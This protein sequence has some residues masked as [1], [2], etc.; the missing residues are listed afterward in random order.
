M[1]S[2]LVVPYRHESYLADLVQYLRV[3]FVGVQ[4]LTNLTTPLSNA[5]VFAKAFVVEYKRDEIGSH[6]SSRPLVFDTHDS[7]RTLDP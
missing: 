2:L 4:S 1:T 7:R 3:C 5:H 6:H